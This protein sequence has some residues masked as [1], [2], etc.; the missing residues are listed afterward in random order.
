MDRAHCL[1]DDLTGRGYLCLDYEGRAY[2]IFELVGVSDGIGIRESF[3][4][5]PLVRNR[6]RDLGALGDESTMLDCLQ[7][8]QSARDS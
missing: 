6:L 7:L 1:L 3:D 2:L 8:I 5:D 4:I